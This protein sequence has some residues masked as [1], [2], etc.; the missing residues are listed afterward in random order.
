MAPAVAAGETQ[1]LRLLVNVLVAPLHNVNVLAKQTTGQ[2][3]LS[4]GRLS[5]SPGIGIRKDDFRVTSVLYHPRQT[6]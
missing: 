3:V 1:R 4:N 2:D 6:L 5:L